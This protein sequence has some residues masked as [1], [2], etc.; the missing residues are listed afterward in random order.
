MGSISDLIF[1]RIDAQQ[2]HGGG[3]GGASAFG[4]PAPDAALALAGHAGWPGLGFLGSS[5][6]RP[7]R[8]GFLGCNGR[9]DML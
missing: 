3:H 6:G 2:S 8:L 1:V 9:S 5:D 7:P 4:H